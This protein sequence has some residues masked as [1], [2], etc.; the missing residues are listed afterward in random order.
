[1]LNANLAPVNL[2]RELRGRLDA[3]KAKATQLK[4]VEKPKL[5]QLSGEAEVLL[6]N[7]PTDLKRAEELV[8]QYAA[9]IISGD[10]E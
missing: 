3:L 8:Q 5:S 2:R 4:V 9:A 7:R 1:M 6:Y 10:W